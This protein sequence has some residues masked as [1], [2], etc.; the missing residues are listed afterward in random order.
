[1]SVTKLLHA[2]QSLPSFNPRIPAE[3]GVVQYYVSS[4]GIVGNNAS[5]THVVNAFQPV[6]PGNI[7][8]AI[9]LPAI[10]VNLFVA[11]PR[12]NACIFFPFANS[13]IRHV[14]H[15]S[16]CMKSQASCPRI[17]RLFFVFSPK[18]AFFGCFPFP[19]RILINFRMKNLPFEI[20]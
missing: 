4:S 11:Q 7:T 14:W 20:F 8:S 3:G 18:N 10:V 16:I 2:L 13:R 9:V 1:M 15:A 6:L 19:H 12:Q 5:Y 17:P